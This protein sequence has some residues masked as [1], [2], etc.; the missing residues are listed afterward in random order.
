LVNTKRCP[1]CGNPL[2]LIR[3]GP[4]RIPLYVHR[5]A[6]LDTCTAFKLDRHLMKELSNVMEN[7]R[8]TN[9]IQ[10]QRNNKGEPI[11]FGEP[12]FNQVNRENSEG[13]SKP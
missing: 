4:R 7:I 3:L 13:T 10:I 12:E 9:P 5:G 8:K 11:I 1:Q 2:H 6:E